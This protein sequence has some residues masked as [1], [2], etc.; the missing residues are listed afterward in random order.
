[1]LVLTR[2]TG[3]RIRI[4]DA[5]ELVVLEIQGDRVRL[6][7]HAPPEI[8]IHRQEVWERIVGDRPDARP[9]SRKMA[10]R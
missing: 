3:E 9:E 7:F 5:V 10:L 4:G 8:P 1:M 6:G 2:K